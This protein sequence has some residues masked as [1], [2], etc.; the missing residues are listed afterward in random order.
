MAGKKDKNGLAMSRRSRTVLIVVC[1]LSAGAAVWLDRREGN[2][3]RRRIVQTW[4]RNDVD[5]YAGGIFK[6]VNI[7]DGD[8]LDIG[9]ADGEYENTRVRLLGIDTPETGAGK[10]DQMYFGPEATEFAKKLALGKEVK[11]ILD[12]KS[13]TR[14]KYGRLLAHLELQDGRTVNEVLVAD[15][16]AYADLRFANDRF[17]R[18]VELQKQAVQEKKGL[19]QNVAKEQLPKWLQRRWKEN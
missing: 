16:F 10:G 1:V 7:V 17:D 14:D 11:V 13:P 3:L 19:W 8:T 12:K 6:V 15:G 2:G 18:Y 9:I 4:P 5:K